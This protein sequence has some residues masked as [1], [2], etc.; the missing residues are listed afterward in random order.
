MSPDR[1]R[2]LW[3]TNAPWSTTGYGSQCALFA[4][5]FA[6]RY[7]LVVS[8]FYGLEG[9]PLEF[10]NYRILPGLGQTYGNESIHAHCRTHFD[11]DI[12]G[13]LV[14]TLL[15]VWVLNPEVWGQLNT[16]CWVPV[17]HDPAPPAVL[18]FFAKSG[19]IPVAMSEFGRDRLEQ[20]DPLYVPHG[21]DTEVYEPKDQTQ[22]RKS[23]NLPENA[24]VVGMVAANKGNPSRKCFAESLQAFKI[25]HERH[26]DA[27]LFLH[28]ELEGY[29]QGV[30]IDRL[31]AQLEIP[32]EA[33]YITDQERYLFRPLPPKM[34]AHVYSSFDVLLNPAKGEG[35]GLPVLEAQACG[36]P[37]IVT[38]FSAMS[39]VCGAGWKV[40]YEREFT[41]QMSWQALPHVSD[42]VDSLEACYRMPTA[43]RRALS[44]QAR[45][46][47][48]RYDVRVVMEDHW[49]PALGEIE[50]RLKP[51]PIP[52]PLKVGA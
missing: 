37:C 52:K 20:F 22:S 44:V 40:E 26:D 12:R 33:V 8:A 46:H 34:M 6:E 48:E 5:H 51:E 4:P 23:G 27:V 25:F 2:M 3:H 14:L 38:D 24:F 45:Q 35:F 39:E 9:A 10:G 30:P 13:G 1:P 49:L 43:K 36:V 41:P 7:D 29:A 21:V 31:L 19:A 42:I 16:V 18:E 17:D 11:G 47:A 15:D 28:T 32:G 50:E